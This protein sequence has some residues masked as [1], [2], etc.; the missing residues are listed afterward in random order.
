MVTLNDYGPM[1]P[2]D[3]RGWNGRDDFMWGMHDGL[4]WGGWLLMGLMTLLVVG[5]LV[6]L[7]LL[8]VRSTSGRGAVSGSGAPAS[9]AEHLLDERFARGEI[10]EEEYLRRRSVLRGGQP[11]PGG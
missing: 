7:V 2:R 4:G 5:L 11:A 6:G 10:D 3:G 8:V 9:T 1:G